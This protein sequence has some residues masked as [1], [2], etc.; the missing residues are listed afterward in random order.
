M[1]FIFTALSQHLEEPQLALEA[2]LEVRDMVEMAHKIHAVT[3]ACLDYYV[4]KS[5]AVKPERWDECLP[6]F[7][8]SQVGKQPEGLPIQPKAY[9]PPTYLEEQILIRLL[10]RL[11]VMINIRNSDKQNLLEHW[12]QENRRSV[13]VWNVDFAFHM[14]TDYSNTEGLSPTY[15]DSWN[16]NC[17][18]EQF[19]S[20]MEYIVDVTAARRDMLPGVKELEA[21]LKNLPVEVYK[22]GYHAA[23]LPQNLILQTRTG[24]TTIDDLLSA[25]VSIDEMVEKPPAG[26]RLYNE[27]TRDHRYHYSGVPYEPYRKYGFAFWQA[28]RMANLGFKD[29]EGWPDDDDHETVLRERYFVWQSIL[30]GIDMSRLGYHNVASR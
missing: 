11:Q 5:M 14:F 6:A 4:E 29:R 10:W 8:H 9:R 18:K 30:R 17:E 23:C 15:N 19:L 20:L 24:P 1:T 27:M 3:H 22:G 25:A 21:F 26:W 28:E 12:P 16:P 2:A 13:N 7:D